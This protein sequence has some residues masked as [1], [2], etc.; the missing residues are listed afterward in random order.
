MNW[1]KG[2]KWIFSLNCCSLVPKSLVKYL[3][4][5]HWWIISPLLWIKCSTVLCSISGLSIL[6]IDLSIS[7]S[8]H[9]SKKSYSDMFIIRNIRRWDNHLRPI[10]RYWVTKKNLFSSLFQVPPK[11]VSHLN[12]ERQKVLEAHILWKD[13]RL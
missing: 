6:Y 13:G 4:F 11:E 12:K 10:I 2:L 8:W 7:M 1:S 9:K 3:S 5:S